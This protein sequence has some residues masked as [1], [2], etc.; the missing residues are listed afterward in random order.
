MDLQQALDTVD[1][2]VNESTIRKRLNKFNF[3]GRCGRRKPLLWKRN[4]KA[5]LKFT[6]ENVD[7]DQDFWNNVL[8][9]DESKTEL[10]G[11]QNRGHVWRK[12]NTPF[13]GCSNF[14]T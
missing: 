8:W 13:Q 11:H 14:F 7:K 2:K 4:M 10:F 3:H 12:P 6:R 9:T 1:V 5:R